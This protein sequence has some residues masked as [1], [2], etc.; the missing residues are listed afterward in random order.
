MGTAVSRTWYLSRGF[1][2]L[3]AGALLVPGCGS[4]LL[5]RLEGR[6]ARLAEPVRGSSFSS[7]IFFGLGGLV[8]GSDLDFLVF[9]LLV[10]N[11][12]TSGS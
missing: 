1:S 11:A 5:F 12:W 3:M 2:C 4:V 6:C 8:E 7:L 9:F 10:L